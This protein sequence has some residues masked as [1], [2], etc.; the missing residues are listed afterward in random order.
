MSKFIRYSFFDI[1]DRYHNLSVYAKCVIKMYKELL[2]VVDNKP[3]E[4]IIKMVI[5]GLWGVDR[6]NILFSSEN[7]I[8][9]K[10]LGMSILESYPVE[11]NIQNITLLLELLRSDPE[12]HE[13]EYILLQK[14]Y[15]DLS[16]H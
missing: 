3:K 11:E 15:D 9:F 14:K 13:E 2:K 8:S 7:K 16:F 6:F 5:S 4:H 10:E 12:I 1:L